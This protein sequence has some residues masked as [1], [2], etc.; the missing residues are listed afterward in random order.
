MD[1]MLIFNAKAQ[2]YGVDV[3][4]PLTYRSPQMKSKVAQALISWRSQSIP[5]TGLVFIVIF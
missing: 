1:N 3:S 2:R 5:S 4:C